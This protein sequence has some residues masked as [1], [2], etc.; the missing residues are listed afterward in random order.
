MQARRKGGRDHET[1]SGRGNP[2]RRKTYSACAARP[3][4]LGGTRERV[5]SCRDDD[6]VCP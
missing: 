6:T 2:R 5:L 1:G 4:L 3:G